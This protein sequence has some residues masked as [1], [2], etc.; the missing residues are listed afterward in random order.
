MLPFLQCNPA[1]FIREYRLIP[2][3]IKR[4]LR[5]WEKRL[6][7]LAKA[8]QH[9]LV[10]VVML[11]DHVTVSICKDTAVVSGEFHEPVLGQEE[12]SAAIT[13]LVLHVSLFPSGFGI[14]ELIAE[15]IVFTEPEKL[16]RQLTPPVL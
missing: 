2:G 15:P 7:I 16:I 4:N 9:R 10:V 3:R 8:F 6:L 11:P 12:A 14:H 1:P 5:Q 13:H